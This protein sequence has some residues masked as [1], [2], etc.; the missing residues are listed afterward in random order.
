MAF[1]VYQNMYVADTSNDRI[2]FYTPGSN[3]GTTVAGTT[4]SGGTTRAELNNPSAL[5]VDPNGVMYILDAYN[6]RIL[7]W[8]P[9]DAIGTIIVNGRGSGTTLDRIG[10][11][12]AMFVD[13]QYNIYVSEQ[14]NHRVTK[15]LNGNNNISFLVK[16]RHVRRR[17]SSF[18]ILLRWPVD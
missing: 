9:G 6:Y 3:V 8:N 12:G 18:F 14:G 4:G 7:R 15:W 17:S 1:D 10:L 11:S 5:F 16:Q 2:Q 13:G